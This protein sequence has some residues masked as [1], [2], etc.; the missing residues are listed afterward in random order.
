M[1]KQIKL[2]IRAA[3]F[4]GEGVRLHSVIVEGD[5]VRV[6]DSVAGYYTNCHRL[7]DS[8][9]ARAIKKAKSA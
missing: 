5:S 7:S 1:S 9:R 3:A 2:T 8:A 6:Y 4:S